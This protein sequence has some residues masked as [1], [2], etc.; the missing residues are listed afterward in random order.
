MKQL[1]YIFTAL[2]LMFTFGSCKKNQLKKPTDVNVIMDIN[3]ADNTEGTLSFNEGYIRIAE[4]EYI[5]TRQEGAPIE[6]SKEFEH[7]LVINFNAQN[8]VSE[9]MG[10]IPQGNYTDLKIDFDTHEGVDQPTIEVK[11][12]Y[13]DGSSTNWPILFQFMSSET[14]VI[15]GED[16]A[17]DDIILLDK[18]IAAFVNVQLDPIY[19]FD[20]ISQNM[21]DNANKYDVDGIQTIVVN[22]ELNGDIYDLLA[23]RIDE[24][25]K[26]VFGE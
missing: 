19:W 6:L 11:G 1:T 23:D 14:F 25:S 17:G 3:R 21:L 16:D 13:T 24:S 4:F 8:F 10:E 2:A 26:A 15:K 12:T 18:D 5:G 20:I 22:E 7:G 9:L